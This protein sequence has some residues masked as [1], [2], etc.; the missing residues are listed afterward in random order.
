MPELSTP[1]TPQEA[2]CV[3]KSQARPSARSV[4]SA[5]THAGRP[6]HFTTVARW[7]RQ[8]LLSIARSSD[9][10]AGMQA[11]RTTESAE[12]EPGPKD[13]FAELPLPV[14][15]LEARR[16]WDEQRRPSSRSVA[17]ALTQAGR[18]VHFTTVARWKKREWQVVP[19]LER[20]L[21]AA[22]RKVDLFVPLLTGDPTTKAVDIVGHIVGA[23]AANRRSM[24]A[25]Q[26]PDQVIRESCITLIILLRLLWLKL[27]ALKPIN[28]AEFGRTV[29]QA[30]LAAT[31]AIVQLQALQ[32]AKDAI[33]RRREM[34]GWMRAVRALVRN[35]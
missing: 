3:W 12:P 29:S 2:E 32:R 19:R 34:S 8:G 17:K 6:V 31:E 10:L 24:T 27:F 16:V 25:D 1:I 5:L 11:V 13:P 14:T 26:G 23:R 15:P 21:A 35:H 18:P 20:P 28:I 22:M 9:P 7:Q 4:A 33:A 30:N